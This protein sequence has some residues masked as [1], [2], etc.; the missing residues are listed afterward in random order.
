MSASELLG[1]DDRGTDAD[2]DWEIAREMNQSW[3][4]RCRL[5]D[6]TREDDASVPVAWIELEG[7]AGAVI[8]GD[9]DEEG[10]GVAA[11]VRWGV[12]LLLQDGDCWCVNGC[13]G[14]GPCRLR[15]LYHDAT[16]PWG[17][18]DGV[19]VDFAEVGV[20]TFPHSS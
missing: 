13:A 1:R 10:S 11:G 19:E 3:P 12:A 17:E 6:S 5:R 14:L 15:E 16:S 8:D 20:E 2:W 18:S 7:G 4:P 9:D